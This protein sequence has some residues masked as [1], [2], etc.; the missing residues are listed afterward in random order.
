MKPHHTFVIVISAVTLM[1]AGPDGKTIAYDGNGHG[2]LPC[3]SCHGD[4]F[5]GNPGL[6]AP[7]LAGLTAPFILARLA[8]YKSPAGH[9]AP[10]R[11]EATALSPAESQAVATYLASLPKP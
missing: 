7:A 6:H 3:S 1:A 10:M 9:N 11:Q 4:H 8:H 2:A 5:Q